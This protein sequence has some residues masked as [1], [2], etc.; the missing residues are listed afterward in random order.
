[1]KEIVKNNSSI[2][3]DLLETSNGG[4]GQ[5]ESGGVFNNLFGVID[6]EDINHMKDT[7]INAEEFDFVI[8]I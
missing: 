3:F 7:K 4:T 5:P 8:W 6:T 2:T 1:M